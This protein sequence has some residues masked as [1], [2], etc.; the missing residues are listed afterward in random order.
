MSS[1]QGG[2]RIEGVKRVLGE[3]YEARSGTQIKYLTQNVDANKVLD[4]PLFESKNTLH[5]I[6]QLRVQ[7]HLQQ[8]NIIKESS[9]TSMKRA[10]SVPKIEEESIQSNAF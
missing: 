10:F 5:E 4:K 7:H 3:I 8:G 9:G 2:K 6:A 1:A